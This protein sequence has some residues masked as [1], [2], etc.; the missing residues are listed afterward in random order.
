M[1]DTISTLEDFQYCG[2]LL[3]ILWEIP[4][5]FLRIFSGGIPSVLCDIRS[6][7]WGIPSILWKIFCTMEGNHTMT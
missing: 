4:L 1:G 5:V 6:E 7:M 2:E 3:S